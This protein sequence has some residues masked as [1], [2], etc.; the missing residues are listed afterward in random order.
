MATLDYPS[1]ETPKQA[2]RTYVDQL[3]P[4]QQYEF[5]LSALQLLRERTGRKQ[6]QLR[7]SP[8]RQPLS[9]GTTLRM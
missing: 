9:R 4:E 8:R 2:L 7:T 5:V 1:P 3:P 6:W